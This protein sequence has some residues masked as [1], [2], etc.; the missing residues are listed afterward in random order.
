MDIEIPLIIYLS[1]D[2]VE[3]I[4]LDQVGQL[5]NDIFSLVALN[6]SLYSSCYPLL[7]SPFIMHL[8]HF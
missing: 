5:M 8:H 1:F 6:A 7:F 4:F 3:L 2:L